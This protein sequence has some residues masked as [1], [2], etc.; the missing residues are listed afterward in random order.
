MTD[1]TTNGTSLTAT[2]V[3][4]LVTL[5]S[6]MLDRME[7]R[8][9]GRLDD[10]AQ[11]AAERW[12]RH[13]K[14]LAANTKRITDRF[15]VIEAALD[16]HLQVANIHFAK[17]HDSEIATEARVKPVRTAAGWLWAN[18]KTIVLILF[19][20]LGVLGLAEARALQ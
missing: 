1:E 11:G 9:I 10:N 2:D 12:E 15:M 13:D 20:L 4:A 16:E 14:E 5:M 19:A 18:W 8:I 7:G 6:G 3:T 17:E